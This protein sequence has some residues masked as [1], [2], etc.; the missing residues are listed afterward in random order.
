MTAPKDG[1]PS[2]SSEEASIHW[3]CA[4]LESAA[5]TRSSWPLRSSSVTSPR[6]MSVRWVFFPSTRTDSTSERYTYSCSPLRLT[7]R[8]TC[9]KHRLRNYK[10]PVNDLSPPHF[11]QGARLLSAFK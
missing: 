1:A 3:P 9:I 6:R 2:A 10:P 8:F 7:V 4:Y 5:I 11:R